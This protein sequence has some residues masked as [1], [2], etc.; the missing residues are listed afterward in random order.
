MHIKEY[1][2]FEYWPNYKKYSSIDYPDHSIDHISYLLE[3]GHFHNIQDF[4]KK[5]TESFEHGLFQYFAITIN[6]TG[7]LI[8]ISV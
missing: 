6:E 2:F 5:L 8:Y 1:D 7:N 3:Q 4:L